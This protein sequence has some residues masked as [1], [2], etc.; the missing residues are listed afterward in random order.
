MVANVKQQEVYS[1]I[2]DLAGGAP[3]GSKAFLSMYQRGLR[4][5]VDGL[6]PMEKKEYQEMAKEWSEESPP[7]DVQRK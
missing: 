2:R 5:I 7:T 3:P 4:C 6:S 1:K